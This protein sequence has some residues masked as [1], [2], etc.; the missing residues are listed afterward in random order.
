MS[1]PKS[2]LITGASTGIGAASAL[3]LA[4]LGWRVFAGVRKDQDGRALQGQTQGDLRPV[5]L[6]VTDAASVSAA[7]ACVR[8]GVG[9]EGLT[10]LVNNAGI[11]VAGPVEC[12]TMDDWRRQFD[13][14]VFGALAVTQ[15][16]LPLLRKARGRIV[17]ISSISGRAVTPI[18]G[19]YCASKFA[20]EAISDALRIELRAQGIKIALIEPGAV[21]TPIW[22]KSLGA[23]SAREAQY[24]A[25]VKQLY[26]VLV[27]KL[28]VMAE[29]AA[30]TAMPAR[31][32]VA[33]VVHALTAKRPRIRYLL[34]RDAH[35]GAALHKLLPDS[36]WD[37]LVARQL[38]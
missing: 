35:L 29:D 3:R 12:V 4:E 13:V 23:A 2:V 14:N 30:R 36:W 28:H 22:N 25:D 20:L 31:N 8:D 11:V 26:D 24:P 33:A 21:E 19:P 18:L 37:V 5:L 17:N 15:A 9:A 38:S 6:D 34:G 7:E 1:A 10:G 27:E 16:V 32:V